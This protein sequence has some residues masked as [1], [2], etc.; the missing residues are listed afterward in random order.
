MEK[1][2]CEKCKNAYLQKTEEGYF[3]SS[4]GM[5]YSKAEENLLLGIHYYKEGKLQES[6]DYLMKAI[7]SDGSN[8]T[9][10]LYKALGDGFN[11][12]ED[13]S[14]LEDVY[15]QIIFACE[16]VPDADF[17]KFLEI[18]NDE[19]EKLEL[20]LAKIHVNAFE[21]ADAEK[22]KSIV[23]VILKIQ[24]EAKKFRNKLADFAD[25]Y[26]KRNGNTMVYN[27]SKCFLVTPEIADE[28]GE[29]KLNKI[30][31]DIASHTV[32]TGILTTDIRNLEIYYRCIVMFFRKNKAKYDFLMKNAENFILLA[33]LLEEGNYTSIQGTAATAEKLKITAYSFFEESLKGEMDDAEESEKSVIIIAE[34]PEETTEEAVQEEFQV[35]V[36]D[37]EAETVEATE[38]VV[39]EVEIEEV[40]LQEEATVIEEITEI[41][42]DIEVEEVT[43]IEEATEKE[44]EEVAQ[45]SF[46]DTPVQFHDVHDPILEADT[47]QDLPNTNVVIGNIFDSGA[48]ENE[49]AQEESSFNYENTE[50]APE[51]EETEKAETSEDDE[52]LEKAQAAKTQEYPELSQEEQ[53]DIARHERFK[54]I[55]VVDTEKEEFKELARKFDRARKNDPDRETTLTPK[56]KSNK[57]KFVI[58]VVILIVAIIV[59]NAIRFVPGFIA[60][61]RYNSALELINEKNYTE[62]IEILTELGEYQDS[63][64]KIKECK[65]QNALLLIDAENYTDAKA[66]LGELKGYNADIETKIQICDYSIAKQYLE[67]GKYDKAQELFTALKDY[68]DS[69]DMIKECSYRKALSLIEGKKYEDAIKILS[70]IKKYSDS[71]EKINE[72]KYLYVTENLTSDNETTVKYLKELAKIKYRNSADL[73][74]ELLGASS[75][76]ALKFFVNTSSTDNETSLD[77]VSHLRSAYFHII[78]LDETYYGERLTLKYTTQYN[79]TSTSYVTFSQDNT[80]A[81]VVYPPTDTSGYTVTF[82][83]QTSD[84]T[85]IGSQKITIS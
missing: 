54:E 35:E 14:S 15:E 63:Q 8:H 52:A 6:A 25:A 73:K 1:I 55:T 22:I 53:D 44:V 60:E 80:S 38:T 57:A 46:Q 75:D 82:S 81:I 32:F 3:C 36:E 71:S 12:D 69:K 65:Y 76:S 10:L 33:E 79:Y 83:I 26:N 29:K 70:D 56:K 20:A 47:V 40:N 27:L 5:F 59:V 19:A 13:S 48:S 58:P 23:T 16:L 31:S 11:L 24:E 9:A 74:Q 39:E 7:V 49:N 61:T 67:K 51:T 34:E 77:S 85:T 4:C 37:I 30:K 42:D 41:T 64:E 18:A 62:A 21:A 72:A 50:N 68:G 28:I 84:G 66:L 2:I 78:A 45:T 43:E 17:P